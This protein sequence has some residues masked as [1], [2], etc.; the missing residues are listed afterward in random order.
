MCRFDQSL[1]W[2]NPVC[3]NFRKA[4]KAARV[5]VWKKCDSIAWRLPW[6]GF[7]RLWER[8]VY[9]VASW[10]Y[11]AA[12]RGNKEHSTNGKKWH[13]IGFRLLCILTALYSSCFV[14]LLLC[15]LTALL[16]WQLN[17]T[18]LCSPSCVHH[19]GFFLFFLRAFADWFFLCLTMLP[20]VLASH[21]FSSQHF[22]CFALFNFPY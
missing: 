15:I 14:F 8:A 22:F 2:C 6:W 3:Y 9:G 11:V 4:D 20:V 16:S 13:G 10:L 19:D 7:C 21:N 1:A 18:F 5:L 17:L 12:S